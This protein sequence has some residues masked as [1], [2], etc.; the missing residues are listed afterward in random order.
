MAR[1]KIAQP[2]P[3]SLLVELLTEELPP[4][5]L[6]LLAR[7]FSDEVANGLIRY[8]LK[9]R[10]PD[11]RP[12]ATPRRLAVLV[13]EVLPTAEDRSTEISGPSTKAP[14]EAVAG[15]AKKHG[16]DATALE[17][18]DTPKGQ[19]YVACV[20]IKGA[21]LHTKLAEIVGDA[22]R[23]LPIPKL[24]RWGDGKEQFVRPVHGLVMLHGSRVVP[25]IVL[26]V[27]STNRTFG[28]RFLSGKGITLKHAGD[29]ERALR[30]QGKVIADFAARREEIVK[31]LGKAARDADLVAGDALLNE[32]TALV[33]SPMVYAGEFSPE[34]LA[35][36][37]ECLILSMQQ[38]QRYIP[39]RYRKTGK[40]LPRFLFVSNIAVNDA[41]EIVHGNE[42]VLRA[43]LS[44]AKFFF[45]QDHKTR[46]EARVPRLGQVVY[47]NQLG[48]QLERI[49]RIQLLAGRI[50]RAI[51]ADP[52]L[53]DRAAWLSKADL[54]TEMVGEFPELQGT[55]G[56]YY[57]L[58]DGEPKEV[59][60]A[61]SAHYRPRFAGD[62]LPEGRVGMAVALADKL[63]T[64]S[65][66]FSIGEQPTGD[67][68]PFALRRGALG[69]I[70]I[71]VENQLPLSLSDALDAAFE[72]FKNKAQTDLEMFFTERMRSFF[73]ERGYTAN[74][75]EAVLSVGHAAASLIPK[76]LEAVRAFAKLPEAESLA[77]ANKRVA[78]ILK[79]AQAKGETFS[80][81]GI[82][83]L[84]EPAERALH[85]AL[86]IASRQ[87]TPLFKQGD[88]TGYLKTFAVLKTPVD[89]FFDS[90][91]V[92]VE[93]ATLRQN[94]LALLAD[95]RQAMNRVADISKL[96]A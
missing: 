70:R 47:H 14:P 93:D 64:L 61:I 76:Q 45:D 68:D 53:A 44:D 84:K 1:G 52:L 22:I 26:G 59:A 12:F 36:P 78:N 79:Q 48:T 43:R 32:V 83:E 85:E 34:F 2:A 65:G 90:V 42:R 87:A 86:Q 3:A 11:W 71:V 16:L 75:V 54:L 8:Q 63:D 38:H 74:E 69:V 77:A 58:H 37:E 49:E 94:R 80:N 33:E 89:A 28:H 62:A 21:S 66:L 72:P 39:L 88:F 29:Y 96:A 41:R 95:L 81:A 31:Q 57:A 55:M 60:A 19:I 15:F 92:M 18:R 67:R 25:G 6:S 5:A 27:K 50:A 82:D 10:V 9:Q 7:S 51:G 73:Q 91:M 56:G 20:T 23:K 4:K 13:P 30:A 24:M 46:L 40:L 17:R 35:V